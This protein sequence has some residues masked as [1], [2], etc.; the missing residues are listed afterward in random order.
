MVNSRGNFTKDIIQLIENAYEENINIFKEHIPCSIRAAE[1]AAKGI[2]IF[3]YNS[4]GKV[5]KAYTSLAI[6]ILTH[7]LAD[8]EEISYTAIK[9]GVLKIA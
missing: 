9:K 3:K 6:S 4:S 2:S 7:D 1:S 8:N 5:A